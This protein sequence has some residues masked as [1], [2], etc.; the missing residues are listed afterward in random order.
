[1]PIALDSKH[2]R[3]TTC[4]KCTTCKLSEEI[5]SRKHAM[6]G[7]FETAKAVQR[8]PA[9]L[10]AMLVVSKHVPTLLSTRAEVFAA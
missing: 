9:L 5:H 6:T 1:M 8:N 3:K 2:A 10:K 4:N 7:V